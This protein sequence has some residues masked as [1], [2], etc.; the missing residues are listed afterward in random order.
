M[1]VQ[2]PSPTAGAAIGDMA[3]CS[4]E[5]P[6]SAGTHRQDRTKGATSR[7]ATYLFSSINAC[8][9]EK[10]RTKGRRGR[11]LAASGPAV[12]AWFVQLSAPLPRVGRTGRTLDCAPSEYGHGG[13]VPDELRNAARP[14]YARRALA[15]DVHGPSAMARAGREVCGATRELRS[16]RR[17]SRRAYTR[18]Q[19]QQDWF[20]H[21]LRRAICR[22]A[23]LDDRKSAA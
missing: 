11:S 13:S 6:Q 1:T 23:L 7:K 5:K 3:T 18:E 15:A 16:A 8:D 14:A 12:R 21:S 22:V 4:R 17:R 19:L 10:Q 9:C 2:Q 20:A